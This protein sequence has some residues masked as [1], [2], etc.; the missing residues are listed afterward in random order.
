VESDS[1]K[2]KLGSRAVN[3]HGYQGL[4][5]IYSGQSTMSAYANMDTIL[6]FSLIISS[7][8]SNKKDKY[9]SRLISWK[10]QREALKAFGVS[11]SR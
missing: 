1:A 2:V 10:I 5:Q 8:D 3:Y 4:W 7:Y 11:S 6:V 9:F